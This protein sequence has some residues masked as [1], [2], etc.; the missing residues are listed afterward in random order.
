MAVTIEI[1]PLGPTDVHAGDQ[2]SVEVSV[3]NND[4]VAHTVTGK[5]YARLDDGREF[6]VD[7]RTGTLAPGATFTT[8]L[9]DSVPPNLAAGRTFRVFAQ[10]ETSVS[11]DEDWIEYEVIP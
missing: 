6:P 4:S 3:T 10:A 11:F 7:E 2:V 8:T 9:S 5:V 1:T